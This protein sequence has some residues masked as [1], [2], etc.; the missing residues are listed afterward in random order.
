MTYKYI[1]YK[2]YL[3]NSFGKLCPVLSRTNQPYTGS[4]GTRGTTHRAARVSKRATR[5]ISAPRTSHR[6]RGVYI[7]TFAKLLKIF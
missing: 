3:K 6:D 4:R 1:Q 7:I 2:Y 5:A